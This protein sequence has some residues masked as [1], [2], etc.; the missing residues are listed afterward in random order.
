MST[1]QVN[2]I[3]HNGFLYVRVYIVKMKPIY[4]LD[5]V[6][7]DLKYLFLH[8]PWTVFPMHK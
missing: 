7:L 3:S 5:R 8:K 1:L 6:L 4:G 2:T